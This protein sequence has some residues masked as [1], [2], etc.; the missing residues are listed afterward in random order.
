MFDDNFWLAQKLKFIPKFFLC[1][2]KKNILYQSFSC[3]KLT[4]FFP[5]HLNVMLLLM[6]LPVCFYSDYVGPLVEHLLQNVKFKL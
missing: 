4:T 3:L 5:G 1:K 6:F 2:V